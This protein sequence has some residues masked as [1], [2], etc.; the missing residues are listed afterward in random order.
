MQL[1]PIG[2]ERTDLEALLK[3]LRHAGV[4]TVIDVREL[5]LSRKRG[6]S[7]KALGSALEREGIHYEHMRCLGA[8]KS[9]RKALHS[10]GSWAAYKEGYQTVLIRNKEILSELADRAA[11]DEVMALLCFE[12]DANRC[13]RSLVANAVS[14][15]SGRLTIQHLQVSVF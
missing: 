14:E 1:V 13:H 12:R 11:E 2:Y 5:P 6:F 9:L 10:G 7:K 3:Q 8:P 4:Q 15:I